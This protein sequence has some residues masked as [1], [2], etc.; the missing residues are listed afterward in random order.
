MNLFPGIH[1]SHSK[2]G[3]E[4]THQES[5]KDN[6]SSFHHIHLR[7]KLQPEKIPPFVL[8]GVGVG[9]GG[10][11]V[12]VGAGPIY[13]EPQS[14]NHH[15]QNNFNLAAGNTVVLKPSELTTATSQLIAELVP[16]YLD[17][18]VVRVVNGDVPVVTKVRGP[19][20]LHDVALIPA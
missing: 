14:Y 9:V 17:P 16:K 6:A 8:G 5:P 12:G 1:G 15:V 20:T 13:S 18:D 3:R 4:T 19:C 11:G 7:Q 10:A 2:A